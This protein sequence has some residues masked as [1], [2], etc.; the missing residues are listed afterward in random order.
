[1]RNV[2]LQGLIVGF[3]VLDQVLLL[4]FEIGE[5]MFLGVLVFNCPGFCLSLFLYIGQIKGQPYS[6]NFV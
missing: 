2:L 5:Q 4:W 1:M 3:V 6:S